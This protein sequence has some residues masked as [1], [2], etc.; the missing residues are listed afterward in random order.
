[1]YILLSI[2]MIDLSKTKLN[3]PQPTINNCGGYRIDINGKLVP[4]YSS[5][6]LTVCGLTA[7]YNKEQ[8]VSN[9][10]E[11]FLRNS[12]PIAEAWVICTIGKFEGNLLS[13][14][15]YSIIEWKVLCKSDLDLHMLF[16]KNAPFTFRTHL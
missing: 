11:W 7:L 14:M 10:S 16:R 15:N 3:L 13:I 4:M 12:W 2:P 8:S 1:M 6:D 5:I 9:L